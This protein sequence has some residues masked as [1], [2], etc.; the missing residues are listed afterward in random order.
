[1]L[2]ACVE[3]R[4]RHFYRSQ[5]VG[6]LG[7]GVI[8]EPFN[9]FERFVNGVVT[10]LSGRMAGFT[11]G[12]AIQHHQPLFG[13]SRV[14]V[15]GF[16]YQAQ[17]DGRQHGQQRFYA[18]FAGN[19][20]FGRHAQYQVVR[21]GHGAQDAENLYQT[22]QAG[23]GIVA[24]QSVQTSVTHFRGEGIP[25]PPIDRLHRVHV[26]IE[27]QGGPTGIVTGCHAP[28]VVEFPVDSHPFGCEPIGQ[29]IGPESFR[30]AGGRQCDEVLEQI[31]GFPVIMVV[32]GHECL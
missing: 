30:T 20:F 24:S 25:A 14:H 27:Q 11:V 1:M 3:L 22:A 12:G 13:H 10:F 26:G 23:T 8:P 19:L 9:V 6:I 15:G 4:H 21:Q 7:K 18:L 28:Q 2:S 17:V 5:E 16:A 32:H 29:V 31:N